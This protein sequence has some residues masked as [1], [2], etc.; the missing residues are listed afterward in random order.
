MSQ[1]CQHRKHRKIANT[2]NYV[3]ATHITKNLY[4][5][6]K[7]IL[8]VNI[9]ALLCNFSLLSAFCTSFLSPLFKLRPISKLCFALPCIALLHFLHSS[10]AVC[11]SCFASPLLCCQNSSHFCIQSRYLYS[12]VLLCHKTTNTS[13]HCQQLK[14]ALQL[15]DHKQFSH[16]QEIYA[17]DIA[18]LE[19]SFI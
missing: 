12:S 15:P 8:I 6:L 9:I 16:F 14:H 5:H 17:M 1:N 11:T 10:S 2:A 19:E 4:H 13:K 3:S 18:S 7:S